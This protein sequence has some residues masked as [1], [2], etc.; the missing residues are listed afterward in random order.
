MYSWWTIPSQSKTQLIRFWSY[1]DFAVPSS[2]LKNQGTSFG[3]TEP[4]FWDHS[5]KPTDSSLVMTLRKSGSLVAVQIK[6]LATAIQCSLCSSSRSYR[7]NIATMHFMPWSCV[8]IS[9]T[10]FGIPRSVSSSCT[11]SHWS[12]LIAACIHSTFSGVL[13]VAGLPEYGS[14]STDSQLPLKHLC[15]TFICDALSAL[16]QKAF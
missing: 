15:H 8:K 3:T 11:G 14:L 9:D 16:S 2:G 1:C 4:S 10:V 7:T 12:L 5:H 13:L 6:S